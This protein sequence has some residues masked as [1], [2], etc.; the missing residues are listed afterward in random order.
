MEVRVRQRLLEDAQQ[1]HAHRQ[2]HPV[3]LVRG[4]ELAADRDLALALE[5]VDLL[6]DALE[7]GSLG[8]VAVRAQPQHLVADA[9]L[10]PRDHLGDVGHVPGEQRRVTAA[11]VELE[12]LGPEPEARDLLREV[13]VQ[14]VA[15]PQ[16]LLQ[17]PEL[18]LARGDL[19]AVERAAEDPPGDGEE[20]PDRLR[21]DVPVPEARA[22]RRRYAARRHA[23]STRSPRSPNHALNDSGQDGPGLARRGG[24]SAETGHSPGFTHGGRMWAPVGHRGVL[25]A[26]DRPLLVV[27]DEDELRAGL[28]QD[29]GRATSAPMMPLMTRRRRGR[30]P[31]CPWTRRACR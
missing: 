22:G 13:V 17:R 14:L 18:A 20:L 2:R 5:G 25:V 11:H 4:R 27:G 6:A 3:G 29:E 31:C 7:Q 1:L 9:A 16:A 12:H 30:S 28:V 8:Q 24:P 21:E 15:D 26:Q 19:P 10:E 23:S